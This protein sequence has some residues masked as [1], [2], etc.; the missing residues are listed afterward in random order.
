MRGFRVNGAFKFCFMICWAVAGSATAGDTACSDSTATKIAPPC[1]I[2]AVESVTV[3]LDGS[4]AALGLDSSRLEN[5]LRTDLAAADP[6]IMFVA[7]K[8]DASGAAPPARKQRV[9]Y[10][11]TIWTVG[12][13]FPIALFAE[14]SL[15]SP[16]GDQMFEARLL[17]HTR[18]SELDD[19]VRTALKSAAGKVA[20]D[21]H[22]H[23]ERQRILSTHVA[24]DKLN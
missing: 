17:G 14:C 4:A 23:R 24:T 10:A 3:R 5:D 7:S 6:A 1:R 19:T 9:R 16:N 11:C 12:Q 13:Y 8:A 2:Q 20:R 21:L 22:A 18:R 15:R